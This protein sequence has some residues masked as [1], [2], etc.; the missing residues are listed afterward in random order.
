MTWL[1]ISTQR[2]NYIFIISSEAR[3]PKIKSTLSIET[4]NIFNII[5]FHLKPTPLSLSKIKNILQDRTFYDC[6]IEL[7]WVLESGQ[8]HIPTEIQTQADR[9]QIIIE[10]YLSSP[11][12]YF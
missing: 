1:K 9:I 2:K 12:R 6:V 5:M 4:K 3:L 8:R 10:N 11:F 7:S